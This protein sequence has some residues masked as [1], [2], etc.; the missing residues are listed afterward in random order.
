MYISKKFLI[1]NFVFIFICAFIITYYSFIDSYNVSFQI[2]SIG[3][4]L[5]G[6]SILMPIKLYALFL[7]DKDEIE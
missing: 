2:S 3:G 1:I 5:T 7:K 4:L 6:Y